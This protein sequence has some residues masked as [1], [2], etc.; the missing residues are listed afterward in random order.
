MAIPVK[1]P[2]E[3]E[4]LEVLRIYGE[5]AYRRLNAK[6]LRLIMHP[7]EEPFIYAVPEKPFVPEGEKETLKG[8]EEVSNTINQIKKLRK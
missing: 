7:D 3:T 4:P 1:I 5:E 6:R 8:L 2:V